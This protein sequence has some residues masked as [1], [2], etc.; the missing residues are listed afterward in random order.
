MNKQVYGGELR[1]LRGVRCSVVRLEPPPSRFNNRTSGGAR[2][3][4]DGKDLLRWLSA[5]GHYY[6]YVVYN[7]YDMGFFN[8]NKYKN[9]CIRYFFRISCLL[10]VL[11][12]CM[13]L[14]RHCSNVVS[15]TKC[16]IYNGC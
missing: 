6:E 1:V 8:I 13:L 9:I 7:E 10:G 16:V 2:P 12:G 15:A 5:A 11:L 4:P 3:A 14:K